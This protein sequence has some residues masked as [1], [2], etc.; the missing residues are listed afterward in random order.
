[1]E[2]LVKL[3]FKLSLIVLIILA[4]VVAGISFVL[5]YQASSMQKSTAIESAA[6]LAGQQASKIHEHMEG[7]LRMAETMADIMADFEQVES[8]LRRTRFDQTMTAVLD[9][10]LDLVG[11]FVVW[12]RDGLDGID[13]P[14]IGEQS[15]SDNGQYAP[16][17]S[18]ASGRIE[19]K[20]YNNITVCNELIMSG[21]GRHVI[22]QE[23]FLQVVNGSP[24]LVVNIMVP[25]LNKQNNEL[26]AVMGVNIALDVLQPMISKTIDSS[27]EISAMAI[28]TDKGT[29]VASYLLDQIGKPLASGGAVLYGKDL[30]EVTRAIEAGEEKRLSEYAPSLGTNLQLV[31]SPISFADSGVFWSV[32]IGVADSIVLS[33]VHALTIFTIIAALVSVLIGAV[34]VF[35]ICT[36]FTKPIVTVADTLR[37]ISEGE[38]DLTK[39]ITVKSNDEIGELGTYFNATLEKIRNLIIIIK[40]EAV[41]LLGIGNELSSNMNETAAA[42]NQIAANIQS[43][44]GRVMNQSASVRETGATMEQ[45]SGNITKLNGDIEQQTANISQSSTAIEEMLANIQSV[46]QTLVKNLENV[47]RLAEASE[48]G[49]GGLQEMSTD[50]QEIAR[51]SAGLLEINAVMENIAS[52]TN[53][54][55]MNAAIEAAHAGEAGKGFAVVADEI[56]KLAESSSEQS[57]TIST[58]LKKITDSIGKITA[59]TAAVLNKFEAIDTGVKTVATQEENV[60]AAMEEQGAGSRQILEAIGALH[61]I[62]QRVKSGS[63]EMLDGSREVI[64]ESQNLEKVTQEITGGMNEMATGADQIN[65]AV[66][67]V[68]TLSGTNKDNIDILVREVSRFKVE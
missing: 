31:L 16:W 57:K 55:S 3:K 61:D 29:I 28:Y 22:V 4:V 62:T 36:R 44:T 68:N 27:I 14:H 46:T 63:L 39:A 67:H 5:L 26:V 21:A 12:K 20:S 66:N 32:M 64:T 37:D 58:V 11:I 59:S 8:E 56:R 42:V 23:P 40:Q 38:G 10:E 60:R 15:A 51:E 54:L 25:V 18:R 43:I 7:Y 24:I 34:I 35:V 41:A 30:G 52:Q 13:T 50:I 65:L 47:K 2:G 1:M 33:G 48:V 6:R 45:M 9:A 49:R 17:L 53:L 19:R